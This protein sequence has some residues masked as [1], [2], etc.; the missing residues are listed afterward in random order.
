MRKADQEAQAKLDKA[1]EDAAKK[2]LRPPVKQHFLKAKQETKKSRDEAISKAEAEL[3][4][5]Q[6]E[7]ENAEKKIVC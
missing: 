2:R 1:G 3:K 4:K 7:L 6:T 5:F